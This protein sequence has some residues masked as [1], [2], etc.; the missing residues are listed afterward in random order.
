M[1]IVLVTGSYPPD[2]CGVGD[3]TE[4]LYTNAVSGIWKLC[5]IKKWAFS[6]FFSIIRKIN[7]LKASTLV[8][9][10]PTEGYGW[11]I[12]PHLVALYYSFFTKKQF[13]VV[14]HEFSNMSL[15][16]KMAAYLFF[17]SIK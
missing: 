4:K 16:A 7:K 12:I 1:S 2:I 5:Y 15:K 8:L 10:Y 9:Q 3:Y 13:I 6:S 17:S 11:S 14:L